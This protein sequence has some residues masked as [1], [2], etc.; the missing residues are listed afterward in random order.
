[1]QPVKL[2]GKIAL[3]TGAN[4]GIGREAAVTLAKWGAKVVMVARNRERG[5][6]ALEDV[7]KRSGSADVS[8]MLCDFAVQ[9]QIRELARDFR[10]DHQRLDILINNAGSVTDG[11]TVTPDG[12]EQTFAVNHLGYFLLTNLLL[13]LIEKSAPARIVNVSSKG[14]YHGTM[15]F[16]NLQYEKG[17]YYILAAYARSKLGNV[18]FTRELAKRLEGKG[19]LVNCLHPGT[20]A[21]EIWGHAPWYTK[22]FLPLM[23]LFMITAEEGG[24]RIVQLAADPAIEGKTGGYYDNYQLKHP[25]KLAQDEAVAKKLWDVSAQLVGL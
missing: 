16:D 4:A 8:L 25:A 13:D 2:S 3:V 12:L 24:N 10:K 11:R 22:P 15:P 18:M 19:V 5:Q 17:G 20:V 1:M 23:R 14:H 6:V 9:Q 21:T 7:K